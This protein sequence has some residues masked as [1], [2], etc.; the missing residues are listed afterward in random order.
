MSV[1]V[2]EMEFLWQ[3]LICMQNFENYYLEVLLLLK[4]FI[5]FIPLFFKKDIY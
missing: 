2:L 4:E 1:H 5:I 3:L